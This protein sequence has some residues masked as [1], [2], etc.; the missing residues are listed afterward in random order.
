MVE[1]APFQV[2]EVVEEEVPCQ[3]VEAAY[4]TIRTFSHTIASAVHS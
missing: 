4:I 1:E 3:E 2:E